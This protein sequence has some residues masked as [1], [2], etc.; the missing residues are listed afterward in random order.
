[1]DGPPPDFEDAFRAEYSAVVRVCA[2]IVGSIPDAE[3]VAQDAFL[4][5]FVRWKRLSRYDKPGA[6]IRRVAIR[7]AV[8]FA[9]RQ[10]R[11]VPL[12]APAADPANIAAIR[13]D[14]VSAIARL[15]P[16]QRACVVLCHLASWPVGE[17]AEAL[18]CSEATV[19]VHLHRAR[20]ALASAFAAGAEE[21]TDGS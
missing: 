20:T 15:T 5:A 6:W 18:G 17:V 11:T 1:V 13:V 3:A 16:K 9:E 21:L 8:R 4:K 2:P 12:P 10:R 19:R 7:D 14:L